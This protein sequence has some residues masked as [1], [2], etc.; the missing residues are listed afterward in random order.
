MEQ[1]SLE[2]IRKRTESLSP[3]IKS[4]LYSHD[5]SSIIQSIGAKHRLHVDKIG[6]LEEAVNL[7]LLG[8]VEPEHFMEY[9]ENDLGIERAAS[10][11]IAQDLNEQLFSKIRDSLRQK[12]EAAAE[13]ELKPQTQPKEGLPE[14]R[15][16]RPDPLTSVSVSKERVVDTSVPL[17]SGRY[18]TD[19]YREPAD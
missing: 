1:F 17:A 19:P 14:V 15:P 2:E 6:S 9:A 3:A 16:P 12:V 18:K 10:E 7:V 4:L 5:V 11:A 8:E 13:P